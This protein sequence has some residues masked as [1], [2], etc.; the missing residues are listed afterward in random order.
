MSTLDP[1]T[2]AFPPPTFSLLDVAFPVALRA[3]Y[4]NGAGI[5]SGFGGVMGGMLLTAGG[6]ANVW[7]LAVVI[8][9][10]PPRVV[11]ICLFQGSCTS[12]S[13]Q[14]DA[15]GKA[16]LTGDRMVIDMSANVRVLSALVQL[17]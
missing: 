5:P 12:A 16:R 10:L 1:F 17:P 6:P 13:M 4:G 14:L 3:M 9:C 2:K 7:L 11:G 8:H 15:N